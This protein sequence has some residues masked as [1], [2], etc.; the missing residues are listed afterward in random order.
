[1]RVPQRQRL[2]HR[3]ELLHADRCDKLLPEHDLGA[4]CCLQPRQPVPLGQVPGRR[5]PLQ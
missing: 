4:R 3:A 1:M 5:M 2:P